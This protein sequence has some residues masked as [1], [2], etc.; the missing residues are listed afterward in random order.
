MNS[1]GE[2]AFLPLLSLAC[3]GRESAVKL[4]GRTEISRAS[5]LD[6]GSGRRLG[7]GRCNSFLRAAA[8]AAAISMDGKERRAPSIS[9][10][11]KPR[12]EAIAVGMVGARGVGRSCNNPRSI[13][14]P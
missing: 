5:L 12:I 6:M 11:G 3:D 9:A 4:K 2:M 13:S 8:A 14:S 7:L 10:L 1:S